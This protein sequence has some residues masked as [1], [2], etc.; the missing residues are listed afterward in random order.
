MLVGEIDL[1]IGSNMALAS[2]LVM[3]M[4]YGNYMLWIPEAGA[5]THLAS[6][7]NPVMP[8]FV[9]V[10]C[11][12]L[13]MFLAAL[14]L[15]KYPMEAKQSGKVDVPESVTEIEEAKSE[16]EA[17][18]ENTFIPVNLTFH[19]LSYEVKASTGK[20][21]LRL[22]NDVSGMF[23]PGRSKYNKTPSFFGI[24]APSRF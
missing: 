13:S 18:A 7:W 5:Q 19:N 22:L 11:I 23:R 21:T 4:F 24:F 2:I 14:C 9:I 15:H 8:P 6:V 1:S 3:V 10:G 17:E 16:D 20:K 12:L